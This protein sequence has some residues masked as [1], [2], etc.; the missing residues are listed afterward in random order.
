MA[1]RPGSDFDSFVT[2]Q[3]PRFVKLAYLLTGNVADADD[4]VQESLTRAFVAW[5]QIQRVANPDGYMRQLMVNTN[6]RRFRRHR[7]TEILD[8]RDHDHGRP[9]GEFA[10]IDDRHHLARA[11]RSFPNARLQPNAGG[12]RGRSLLGSVGNGPTRR[13][14]SGRCARRR[15]SDP[16]DYDNVGWE[17]CNVPA[18]GVPEQRGSVVFQT[19]ASAEGWPGQVPGSTAEAPTDAPDSFL[20]AP[21]EVVSAEGGVVGRPTGGW[22]NEVIGRAAPNIARVSVTEPGITGS[23][24][25]ENGCSSSTS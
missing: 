12:R 9:Q 21:I 10:V 17:T 6:L 19:W 1:E 4:L 5:S 11:L 18:G 13:P 16:G 8:G 25:V 22:R 14:P 15:R 2:A 7:V 3:G 23:A 24:V 20:V